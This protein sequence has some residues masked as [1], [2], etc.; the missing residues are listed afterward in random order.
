MSDWPIEDGNTLVRDFDKKLTGGYLIESDG[1]SFRRVW[2]EPGKKEERGEW[3]PS[4]SA[5]IRDAAKD[6]AECG[7]DRPGYL[8]MLRREATKA[9]KREKEKA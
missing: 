6:W 8:A 3:L 9:E 2:V 1:K 4:E 5:A 7:S